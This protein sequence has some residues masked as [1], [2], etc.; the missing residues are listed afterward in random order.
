MT[1]LNLKIPDKQMHFIRLILRSPDKGDGWRSVSS[2]LREFAETMVSEQPELY[3]T[4]HDGDTLMLRLTDKGKTLG[5]C[6]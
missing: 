3:E 6:L 5:M 1:D 2:T 4:M